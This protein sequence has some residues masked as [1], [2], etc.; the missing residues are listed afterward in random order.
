[1]VITVQI[2]VLLAEDWTQVR[3]IYL[4]GISTGHAT[5]QKEAPSW[6]NWN[7]GHFS[8]CRIVARLGDKVLGWAALSPVSS[9]CVYA[10]VAEVSVYV[11]Q[12]THGKGIGS[13]LLKSLIEKSEQNGIWTLQ[14][15][16]FPENKS[17]LQLHNKF[18]F[19]EVGRR[20]R[21][22]QMNGIWRDVILVERRSNV[23][24]I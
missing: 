17:S 14:A 5:F 8:E 16:I 18:G 6:E 13:K 19:R 10:G 1:M 22:G 11:R 7:E 21:L 9:R 12:R 15:G 20:E 2:D 3:E 24:G 23:A 4:E